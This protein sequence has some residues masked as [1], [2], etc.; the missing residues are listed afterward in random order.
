[1]ASIPVDIEVQP[2]RNTRVNEI[3]VIA[4]IAMGLL[5]FLCLF[6]YHPNDPSWNA[7]G[8]SGAHNWV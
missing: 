6:S 2:A 5:L 8:E 4:L 1:M 7:A 3:I